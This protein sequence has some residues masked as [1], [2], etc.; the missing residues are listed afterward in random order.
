MNLHQPYKSP[1]GSAT[2]SRKRQNKLSSITYQDFSP[3]TDDLQMPKVKGTDFSAL[4]K[5]ASFETM[6][7]KTR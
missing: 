7:K 3:F 4:F 2:A 1:G 5:E 6:G